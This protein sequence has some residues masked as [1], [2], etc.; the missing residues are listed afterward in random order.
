MVLSDKPVGPAT[1]PRLQ[2]YFEGHWN[3][4]DFTQIA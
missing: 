1:T 2:V 3:A 4:T